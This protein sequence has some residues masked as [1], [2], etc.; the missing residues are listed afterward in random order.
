MI[1]E[2]TLLILQLSQ[3]LAQRPR[4]TRRAGSSRRIVGVEDVHIVRE[5][6]NRFLQEHVLVALRAP[7]ALVE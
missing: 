1:H 7:A 3:A 5:P 6:V 2:L 4:T